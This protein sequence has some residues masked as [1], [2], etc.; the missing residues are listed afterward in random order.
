MIEDEELMEEQKFLQLN[1]VRQSELISQH[2]SNIEERIR[3]A[4]SKEA[5]EQI[6]SKACDE[7][8]IECASSIV[9]MALAQ[10]IQ[11]K[12]ARYWSKK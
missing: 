8:E 1:Q 3:S 6:A 7:F 5:A 2:C 12:V 10:Y 4:Q 11:A 9:R